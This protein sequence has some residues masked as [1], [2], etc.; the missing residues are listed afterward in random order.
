MWLGYGVAWAMSF[1]GVTQN[2]VAWCAIWT[3]GSLLTW[4]LSGGH[5]EDDR[6]KVL[7]SSAAVTKSLSLSKTH[8]SPDSSPVERNRTLWRDVV[9]LSIY[10]RP[11]QGT[12]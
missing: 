12:S 8:E 1:G 2:L 9:R 7:P 4:F 3:I 5:L 10:L 6:T 11:Q